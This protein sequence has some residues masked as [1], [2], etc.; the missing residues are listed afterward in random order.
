MASCQFLLNKEKTMKIPKWL[1]ISALII[2]PIV[3]GSFI[4]AKSQISNTL[5]VT[6][7]LCNGCQKMSATTAADG[8]YTWTYPVA[9]TSGYVTTITGIAQSTLGST[10]VINLQLDG[11]VTNTQA[12]VRV[13][14]T[15][16]TVVGLLGLS[17]LSVPASAGA[18]SIQMTAQ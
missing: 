8:T 15:Q 18:T 2:A 17:I 4:I 7:G 16:I 12:K 1:L 14:R 13:T 5:P 10:D 3:S 6:T 9:Y 11:P